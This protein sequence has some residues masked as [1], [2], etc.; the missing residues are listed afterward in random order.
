MS[1]EIIR[2]D[3]SPWTPGAH[4]LE[5]KKTAALG[6]ATLLEFGAGFRDPQ[7]C[8]NGHAGL[9]LEGRLGLEFTDGSAEI[10]PGEG[11]VV[12]PGTRHRAF[13]AGPHA[14]RSRSRAASCA[15]APGAPAGRRKR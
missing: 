4:P 13:T 9:V 12:E 7:W 11:F 5:R 14:V 6:A 1:W 8:A 3:A 2:F 10:G 15:P